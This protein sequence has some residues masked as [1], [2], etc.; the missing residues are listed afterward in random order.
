MDSLVFAINAVLPIVIMVS[1][2]YFLKRIRVMN[3]SFSK[4][5]N[6]LVFRLFLPSM[7]F[8]N[9]FN[10]KNVA[11]S[12]FGYILYILLVIFFLFLI[13]LPL[14][15]LI[16]KKNE[17][18]G[19]LLQGC[20]RSNFALVGIPLAQ[21]LFGEEGVIVATILSAALIPVLNILAVICLS[22]F[23][24]QK[25]RIRISN[26]LL[27][28]IKNLLIQ[29]IFL[30]V[31]ALVLKNILVNINFSFETTP[32]YKVLQY[33]SSV[34]T[35]LALLVLGSQFEFSV[36]K[37]LK[38]ELIFGTAFKVF[39]SPVVA[40]SI[41]LLI[42][43]FNGAHFATFVAVFATPVAVS[44]VPMAQEMGSDV[45]LAGQLV[46]WSTIFSAVSV[47]VCSYILRL[48]NIF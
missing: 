31:V 2:G 19:A 16:T 10:I 43:K 44:S 7:L 39:I 17:C 42:N 11:I 5:A 6:K 32:F 13:S 41:A 23:N 15:M 18:R 25:Q 4:I 29:S 26:I 45:S 22:I 46:V 35:P 21:S 14:V 20:F 36:I 9:V 34:A 33:F 37:S 47:F 28:I 27:D 8:L 1:V 40:I 48:I 24:P 3:E 38:K 12:D 30:G